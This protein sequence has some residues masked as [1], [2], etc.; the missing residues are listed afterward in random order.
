[1]AGSSGL[2]QRRAHRRQPLQGA[3]DLRLIVAEM[4]YE[5]VSVSEFRKSSKL[6]RDFVD[7]AR[8]Q[9]FCRDAAI[10]LVQRMPQYCLRLGRRLADVDVAPQGDGRWLLAVSG[11]ALAVEIGLRARL[12]AGEPGTRD[13][14]LS[15]PCR[16]RDRRR[17]T[18]A[19]PDI[20]GLG[21]AQ[22]KA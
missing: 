1:L 12:W 9:R 10:A 20:D 14:A 3:Q 22:C 5:D 4:T 13:P 7:R 15:Q 11:A 18:G 17:R 2:A 6:F 19:D 21:W 8:D 16:A